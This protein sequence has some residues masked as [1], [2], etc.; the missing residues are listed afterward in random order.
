MTKNKSWR[1]SISR[2]YPGISRS[3]DFLGLS[4][5]AFLAQYFYPNLLL[6]FC[7][8]RTVRLHTVILKDYFGKVLKCKLSQSTVQYEKVKGH[9]YT[10]KDSI[11]RNTSV[12]D[13]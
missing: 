1:F 7:Y 13:S 12:G 10:W 8:Y 11:G 3:W 4:R 2:G 9:G 6:H 5:A